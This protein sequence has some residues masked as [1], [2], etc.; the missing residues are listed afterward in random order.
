[1]SR[2]NKDYPAFPAIDEDHYFEG[3]TKLE[4]VAAQVYPFYLKRAY[5]AYDRLT[6]EQKDSCDWEPPE[7][8][9]EE[10]A[11]YAAVKFFE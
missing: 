10:D 11:F 4:Y 2:K 9:A 3:M 6:E 1:M 5:A 7:I 8:Q